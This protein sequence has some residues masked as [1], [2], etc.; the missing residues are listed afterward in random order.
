MRCF[1]YRCKLQNQCLLYVHRL[2]EIITYNLEQEAETL[3]S[4][5]TE[6]DEGYCCGKCKGKRGRGAAGKVRVF[7]LLKRGGKVYTK[8]ITDAYSAT[9][10]PI[11][12]RKVLPDIIVYSDCWRVNNVLD[13]SYFRHFK[14][15]HSKLF[16]DKANHIK[17]NENFWSQAKRHMRKF[18]GVSM[19][20]FGLSLKE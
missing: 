6:V 3:F 17:R 4:G 12:E 18:N 19:Q 16:A 9:L 2:R 11:I 1:T 14:I 7:G 5:E 10:F 8:S 13:V 15:N 20:H